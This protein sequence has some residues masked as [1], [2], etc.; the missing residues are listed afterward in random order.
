MSTLP[1]K[2]KNRGNLTFG[3]R[4]GLGAHRALATLNEVIAGGKVGWVLE[5]DLKNFFGPQSK[6]LRCVGSF[7][8]DQVALSVAA[9]EAVPSLSEVTGN[10][11]AVNLSRFEERS[12][13]NPHATFCGSRRRVTAS[14]DPVKETVRSP[15]YPVLLVSVA[16]YSGT[17]LTRVSPMPSSIAARRHHTEHSARPL[18][19]SAAVAERPIWR[20]IC[21]SSSLE[22]TVPAHLPLRVSSI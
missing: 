17:W 6:G 21:K 13:G 2:T 20:K 14:G 15:T 7:P 4:P 16:L 5:A 3:G 1:W 10:R 22:C 11:C 18:R 9:T 19:L 8:P 12:A